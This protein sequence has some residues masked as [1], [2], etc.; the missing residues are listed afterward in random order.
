MNITISGRI[1][2]I[3]FWIWA[4]V[5]GIGMV[6][7]FALPAVVMGIWLIIAAILAL[8]GV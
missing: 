7:A 6:G 8:I 5:F 3:L 1:G 2:Q 4:I